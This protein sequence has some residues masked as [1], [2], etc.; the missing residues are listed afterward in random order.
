MSSSY[1]RI[2]AP[3]IPMDVGV[4]RVAEDKDF[5]NLKQLL[6]GG[7]DWKL[8]YDKDPI[9]VWTKTSDNT[10]FKMIKVRPP[11]ACNHPRKNCRSSKINLKIVYSTNQVLHLLSTFLVHDIHFCRV[12]ILT[13]L[14]RTIRLRK[15]DIFPSFKSLN[16]VDATPKLKLCAFL[17]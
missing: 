9:K 11:Q 12:P 16:G 6:D 10:N 17:T 5:L 1:C 4:V 3:Q 15:F 13:L 2:G 8:D 7:N 14:E